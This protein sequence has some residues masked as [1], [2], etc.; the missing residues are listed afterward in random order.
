MCAMI[1]TVFYGEYDTGI[2]ETKRCP[3]CLES[4]KKKVKTFYS[5][6]QLPITK[7]VSDTNIT[8]LLK[9]GLEVD[10]QD[11]ELIDNIA[12]AKHI[13]DLKSLEQMVLDLIKLH[14]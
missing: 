2:G 5:G 4:K 13:Q 1:H 7:M 14:I 11:N 12:K 3:V 6:F 8:K 10:R 9:A